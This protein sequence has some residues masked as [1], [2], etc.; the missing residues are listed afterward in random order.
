M[1]KE[2]LDEIY[3]RELDEF[4]RWPD[5]PR[6]DGARCMVKHHC[7]K[8]NDLER[9]TDDELHR[10]V[11]WLECL[12]DYKPKLYK[13]FEHAKLG[14]MQLTLDEYRDELKFEICRRCYEA[15]KNKLDLAHFY[16]DMVKYNSEATY[17][18]FVENGGF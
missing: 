5:D 13:A 1:N 12:K 6:S 4:G 10:A 15:V 16:L 2:T 3:L 18:Y 9:M 8:T 14:S 7:Y 17:E 11:L